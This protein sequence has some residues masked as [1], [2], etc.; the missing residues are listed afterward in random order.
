MYNS[1][2]YDFLKINR[3]RTNR[4]L[5]WSVVCLLL[6]TLSLGLNAQTGTI[7]IGS[8]TTNTNYGSLTIPIQNYVYSYSQQ[9]VAAEEFA[10]GDGVAGNITKIRWMLPNIGNNPSVY[11]DWTIWIGHTDKTT[12]SSNTDWVDFSE[13][14]QVFMGNIH[15]DGTPPPANGVWFEL[16]FS[17]PF[18]YDGTSN[19]VI[20]VHEQAPDYNS[21]GTT[22]RTY[23]SNPNSGIVYRSNQTNS[24]PVNPP[25]ANG[26]TAIL[27]Q[28][29]FEGQIAS[30][31]SISGLN[32]SNATFTSVDVSWT[33]GG[34][35]TLWDIQWGTGTFNPNTNI[36]TAEGS[37]NALTVPSYS[38][39]NLT[40]DTDYKIY[41]RSNCGDDGTSLWKSIDFYSGFCTPTG[42]VT[43]S[44]YYV[45]AFS[46]TG[47]DVN[48]NYTT[49]TGLGYVNETGIP[50]S[51]SPGESFDWSISASL[52]TNFFY[53]WIDWNGNMEFE[54]SERIY[55]STGF[56][57]SPVTGTYTIDPM[58]PNGTYRMRV[59]NIR[60]F[61]NAL[62]PC[63]PNTHG[64]Y[65]DFNIVVGSSNC[66]PISGL[67]AE[68]VTSTSVDVQWTAG[69]LETL[70]DIQWGIDGFHPEGGGILFGSQ[71]GLTTPNYSITDLIPD[72][73]Y[74]I[75]VRADCGSG[76][77][78]IWESL[79]FLTGY[80][81]PT[82]L[83]V[84]SNYYVNSFTIS[85]A[86]TDLSYSATSGVSY[87]DATDTPFS[88]SP[89]VPFN[90]SISTSSTG[91]NYYHIWID[92]N[93]NMIFEPSELIYVS[94]QAELSP[95]GGTYT[96]DPMQIEGT[97]RM[98][99]STTRQITG[100]NN[101]PCGPN[102]HGNYVD[103]KV[104][105]GSPPTCM[106]VSVPTTSN[107]TSTSVDVS[108]MEGS[109]ET[110]W[111]IQ[112][113]TD[114]FHP[115]DGGTLVGS[116]SGINVTG[117]SITDLMPNTEYLAF[118][119]ANCDDG[120][121]S[122]WISVYFRT[123]YCVPLGLTASNDYYISE[124]TTAGALVDIN[125]IASSGVG[126]VDASAIT[127]QALQNSTFSYTIK[128]NTSQGFF[129]V[130]ADMNNN[131]TFTDAGESLLIPTSNTASS[132]FGIITIPANFPL[133]NY[134]LRIANDRSSPFV[135]S[136][137]SATHG[138]FVDITL[139]IIAPPNCLPPTN[140]TFS[141]NSTTSATLGWTSSGNLFDVEWGEAGFTIGSGTQI[142]GIITNS[143]SIA[144]T[145]DTWYQ[146]YVRQDCST[147]NLSPWQGPF[148]FKTAYCVPIYTVFS[149]FTY[150]CG[151][152]TKITN[153]EINNA[154]IDL[155]NNTNVSYCGVNGYNNFTDMSATVSEGIGLYFSVEV[156]SFLV[157]AMAGVKIWIDWNNNGIFEDSEII[158]QGSGLIIEEEEEEEE[159]GNTY[160]YG[161]FYSIPTGTPVGDYRIRVR[162]VQSTVNFDACSTHFRGETED[163]TLKVI[164]PPTC[165]PVSLPITATNSSATSVLLEWVSTGTSFDIEYGPSGFA[166]GTGTTITEV[167]NP[168][169]LTGLTNGTQYDYYVRQ[170]CG[171]G[172]ESIWRGPVSFT[173]GSYSEKVASMYNTDPQITDIAC[174]ATF[175]IDVPAGKQIASLKV[176]YV[177][178]SAS[179]RWVSEQRSVLYSP[180]LNAGETEV[181]AGQSGNDFPGVWTY[182]RFVDFANG[183]TVKAWRVAGNSGCTDNEVFVEAGTWILTPTFEDIPACPNPPTNLG[184][185]VISDTD[186]ELF[187]TA[188]E[189]GTTHQLKWGSVGFD[190]DATGTSEDNLTAN[191]FTLTG[192][193]SSIQYEFYV[194]RD[195]GS[196][197]FSTWTGPFRF[198]SGYCLP[199]S[200]FVYYFTLF[201]TSDALQNVTYSN[202]TPSTTGYINNT[203][204][205][206][207]QLA[208]ESFSFN[209][210]YVGGASGLRI[211]IDWNNDLVFDD[212][213][214]VF[215]LG[216]N[217]GNKIG[218]ITIASDK[219]PG[220]YRLRVRSEQGASSIPSACGTI[221]FGEA[222]DFTLRVACPTIAPPTGDE[223]Q[224]FING[225]TIADLVVSGTNLVWSSS[226]TFSDTLNDGEPLVDGMTYYVRSENGNCQS[227][228]LAITVTDCA[229][230]VSTPTGE[231]SQTFNAGQTIADLV[232]SGTNLV[233]YADS[234]LTS[235]LPTTTELVHNT[236]YYVVSESGIC[237]SSALAIT[238]TDCANVVSTP[239]GEAS[240]TFAAGQTIADLAVSGSNLVW[241]SS[242]TFSDTLSDSEPLFNGTTYYVR[243]ENGNCQ[244]EALAITVT[245]CVN[246]V[247]TPTGEDSQTFTAGQTLAD[248]VVNG[249]NLVW[250]ADSSLTTILPTT[251]AL[252]NNTTY[253]VVEENLGCQ[254]SPLEILAIETVS[255]T[256]FDVFNFSYYPNPVNDILHFS[257]NQP[258]ENVVV[259]NMLGQKVNVVLSSDKTNL[260]MSDLPTGNYLV[261]ITIEGVAKTIK[262]VKN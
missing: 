206:I 129:Y 236:T 59:A 86:D 169:T 109:T 222:M 111:D 189:N 140:L 202:N 4:P 130:W 89:G 144:T 156:G 238:V 41:V 199:Y 210:N 98:R 76:D 259:S 243:S 201:I 97:Y 174:G 13:L 71:G 95:A 91:L 203:V 220:D 103:F 20:A 16:E 28:L 230:I 232:V 51:V 92:Q 115:D 143:I 185:N 187:W 11:G 96:V 190:V 83:T 47:A 197:D 194:R 116:A 256:D 118:V 149:E 239:T 262:V 255:V 46:T 242:S 217:S 150:D 245:D 139:T 93:K 134:R 104:I 32:T 117:Y 205:I 123:G 172:D 177:M 61:N 237:K 246:V 114:N 31:L 192:L 200:N 70:W 248:L 63:G 235:T 64:N 260:N 212:S 112:W 153:F 159:E 179:P 163:Y 3:K 34:T 180:T 82:G 207:E 113:G 137:G 119:R 9:I 68:N 215:Y 196:G 160:T 182:N 17:T 204:N 69:G 135:S 74:K 142:S 234:A 72:T 75:F 73:H 84:S 43:S 105:V 227:E 257:S 50:F 252:V 100:T 54:P 211:W 147:G 253:Y 29:Q 24:N 240:Q 22:I 10:I 221:G 30:C 19:L 251:T 39:T 42:L 131:F 56:Q 110:S 254:S 58:Q 146:F 145:I 62:S 102:T 168:Y 52:L 26:R 261:K 198:N 55:A 247:S 214:E 165:M 162:T 231:A 5:E 225:Q 60:L 213:E 181:V 94:D 125:Y 48:L 176:E 44:I 1:I 127:I 167:G 166:Q 250:Y 155:A 40:S 223:N 229:T 132:G 141:Q 6:L 244:S 12:F 183:A 57:A 108:W 216:N 37:Q 161:L 23:V 77:T 121:S 81:V 151:N 65:I 249:T 241:S 99:V 152:V 258:I 49:S 164:T 38:I 106:P 88:V 53:I 33:A 154:I 101:T 133:G 90:W 25:A 157:N 107:A 87:V 186:V 66:T 170:N 188:G 171:N 120:E 219:L 136:C 209:S 18:S 122:A 173:A 175:A 226:S 228:S 21:P 218:N 128:Q 208:G 2:F 14:T 124:I 27:P 78:S 158:G 79:D 193:D 35:E 195:C 178:T 15:A 80:C 36:G 8:G 85:N 7:Q 191:S 138:N 184:Y 233:W 126:Y 224:I 45:S 67:T 148:S